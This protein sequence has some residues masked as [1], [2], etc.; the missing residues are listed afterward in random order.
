MT[1]A[2]CRFSEIILDTWFLFYS[3]IMNKES[4][5]VCKN[6]KLWVMNIPIRFIFFKNFLL[7]FEFIFNISSSLRQNVLSHLFCVIYLFVFYLTWNEI[8]LHFNAYFYSYSFILMERNIKM[9]KNESFFV[10]I[11]LLLFLFL[12][13]I[14]NKKQWTTLFSST[15]C[16]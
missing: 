6:N 14:L 7:F 2:F 8:Y 5:M 13:F 9:H 3:N 12:S 4:Q 16:E 10:F 1:I 15:L 11:F